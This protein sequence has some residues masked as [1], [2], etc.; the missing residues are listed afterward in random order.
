MDNKNIPMNLCF[1]NTIVNNAQ[2]LIREAFSDLEFVADEHKYFLHE[3]ELPSVS[4]V[5]ELFHEQFDAYANSIR[6][7]CG[8]A[9]AAEKLR[10]GWELHSRESCD[11]G[12][13][14]H[15]FAQKYDTD[16][17][18]QAKDGYEQAAGLYLDSEQKYNFLPIV[19]EAMVYTEKYAGTFDRL[20]YDTKKQKFIIIDYKTNK[21][22][23]KNFR[24]KKMYPPFENLL[25]TPYNHYVLQLSM[26]QIAL[27]NIG[28]SV[29]S[30]LVHLLPSG[31]FKCYEIDDVTEK[32]RNRLELKK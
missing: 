3:N 4:R 18:L 5:V 10:C 26:Y 13:R 15:L 24:E 8:D 12:K 9:V 16:K 17:S 32:L 31:E 20:V 27:Q 2:N 7:A 21:D 19:T 1:E 22:L 29:G 11:L 14:V 23:I 28:M 25:D 30:L 6:M